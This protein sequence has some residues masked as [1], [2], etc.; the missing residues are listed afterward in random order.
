MA[1]ALSWD[2]RSLF[3]RYCL[4]LPGT[5]KVPSPGNSATACNKAASNIDCLGTTPKRA[6][7]LK[8]KVF[9]IR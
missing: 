4:L 2:C 8:S 5:E 6:D 9:K 3:W 7:A 1:P